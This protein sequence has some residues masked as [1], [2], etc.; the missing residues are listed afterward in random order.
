MQLTSGNIFLTISLYLTTF[1]VSL[2]LAAHQLH[3]L[4]WQYGGR[5]SFRLVL[6]FVGYA[7]AR[8]PSLL[9]ASMHLLIPV[10]GSGGPGAAQRLLL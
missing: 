8:C 5:K 10:P 3:I 1:E 4:V 9:Y 6:D 7:G 2:L